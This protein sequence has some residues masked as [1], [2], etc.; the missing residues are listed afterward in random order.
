MQKIILTIQ[1][2]QRLKE[3]AKTILGEHG[4]NY[5]DYIDEVLFAKID[6]LHSSNLEDWRNGNKI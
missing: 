2:A 4:R 1:E 5:K 3:W 6:A